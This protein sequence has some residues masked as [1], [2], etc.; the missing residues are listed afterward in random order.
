MVEAT[1]PSLERGS[2]PQSVRHPSKESKAEETC[3][4]GKMIK[5]GDSFG[6]WLPSTSHGHSDRGIF[7]KQNTIYWQYNL[8][9]KRQIHGNWKALKTFQVKV[10]SATIELL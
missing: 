4:K 2:L 3:K 5:K 8:F 10:L 6:N 7:V 1:S 9:N